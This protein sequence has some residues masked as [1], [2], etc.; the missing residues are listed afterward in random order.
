MNQPVTIPQAFYLFGQRIAVEWTDDLVDSEDCVGRTS[1]RRHKI[2]LQKPSVAISRPDTAMEVTF[3]H[4]VMHYVFHV[5]REDDLRDNER[6]V[7]LVSQALHQV[8][9]TAEYI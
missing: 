1:Y 2:L 5:L 4:E 9:A 8:F 6:L 3:F 7:E